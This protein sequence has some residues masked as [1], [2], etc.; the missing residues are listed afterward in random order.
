M[1]IITLSMNVYSM[2]PADFCRE[3]RR[4]IYDERSRV[5]K[6][7]IINNFIG[8]KKVIRGKINKIK[9]YYVFDENVCRIHV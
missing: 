3:S 1:T 5:I 4:R 8:P 9:R 6:F 7:K 2:K